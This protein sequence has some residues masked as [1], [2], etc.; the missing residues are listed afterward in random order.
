MQRERDAE[1]SSA[2]SAEHATISLEALD[3]HRGRST[4]SAWIAF[5]RR[6][7]RAAET[8]LLGSSAAAPRAPLV[9]AL[10]LRLCLSLRVVLP[11]GL[12]KEPA[13]L[14][15]PTVPVLEVP[16]HLLSTPAAFA[17]AGGCKSPLAWHRRLGQG[18]HRLRRTGGCLTNGVPGD[19][20]STSEMVFFGEAGVA[21]FRRLCLGD[22]AASESDFEAAMSFSRGFSSFSGAA[23]LRLPVTAAGDS[24]S[25][26]QSGSNAAIGLRNCVRVVALAAA[27]I[28]AALA[29]AEA[30]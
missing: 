27:A 26:R 12:V 9:L 21:A 29:E 14:A 8:L 4:P 28:V 24:A 23:A 7:T 22:P 2:P 10:A 19:V 18:D 13:L 5:N 3:V 11:L 1:P 6:P 20:A 16:A 15:V 30:P 25:R 17:F